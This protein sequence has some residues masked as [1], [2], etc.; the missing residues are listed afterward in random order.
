MTWNWQ[1]KN[2]PNFA[3]DKDKL[4]KYERAFILNAGVII[5]SSEHLSK[6]DKQDLLIQLLSSE[7]VDTSLIEGEYLNCDSVQSSIKK[8][9][10]LWV[11][12]KK[13]TPA[14]KSIAMMMVNLYRNIDEPLTHDTLYNWHKL[15][16]RHDHR[17]EVI[18]KYRTHEEPMEIVSGPDYAKKVHFIAPPSKA[19]PD[20][21][22][23]FIKWFEDTSPSGNY[24]LPSLTR[25]GIAHLWF[26]SIHPFEDGNG[27]IGRGIAE[28]ILSQG[29]PNAM[30]TVLAKTLLQK[31]KKYYDQLGQASITLDINEWLIWFAKIV[32]KAQ[33][34]TNIWVHWIIEKASFMRKAQGQVNERQ[35]KVLLRLFRAGPDGFTGGLS[36]KNYMSIT[37]IAIAT[38]TRDLRD[39]VE[40]N[41]LRK[42][43][44]RKSTRYYLNINIPGLN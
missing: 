6:E 34:N 17:I 4:E 29:Y 36:A 25:A 2:W 39:L 32:I 33:Q 26:E 35:E 13:S 10:G 8:E 24:P 28:K 41:F 1:L 5:G 42:T 16:M 30:I 27:R 9:L 38:T 20:E 21:M 40:K 37:G 44:E 22:S 19:V 43:G 31:R 7:A 18:G 12:T 14:E 15:L 3:W 11:D 23:R